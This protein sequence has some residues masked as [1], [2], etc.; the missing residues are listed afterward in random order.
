MA[1]DF[2]RIFIQSTDTLVGSLIEV[3]QIDREIKSV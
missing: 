1:S 2:F 3:Q